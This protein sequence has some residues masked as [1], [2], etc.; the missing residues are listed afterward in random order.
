[1]TA[2]VADPF[3]ITCA[4]AGLPGAL[5]PGMKSKKQTF[6]T[7]ETVKLDAITGGCAACGSANCQLQRTQ[8]QQ[9]QP[10]QWAR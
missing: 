10:Q 7:V 5:A 2:L 6:E 1:V 9:Q 4:S 8:P 3:E